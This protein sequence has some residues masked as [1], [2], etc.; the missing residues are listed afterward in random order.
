MK[1]YYIE[2]KAIIDNKIVNQSIIVWA[3]DFKKAGEVARLSLGYPFKRTI[4]INNLS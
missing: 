4:L 3:K 2:S 1:K